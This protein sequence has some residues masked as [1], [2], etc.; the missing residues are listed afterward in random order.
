VNKLPIVASESCY[1]VRAT[2]DARNLQISTERA[3]RRLQQHHIL[4]QLT[5]TTGKH[6]GPVHTHCIRN[7]CERTAIVC[8]HQ[9]MG[10]F[11]G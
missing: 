6:I 7:A 3:E 5:S 4:R 9:L 11:F 1:V 2:A 8:H 10:S